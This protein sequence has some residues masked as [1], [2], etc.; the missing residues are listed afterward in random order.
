M[1]QGHLRSLNPNPY[2][3][4]TEGRKTAG[5]IVLKDDNHCKVGV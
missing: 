2:T 1:E 3:D 4:A 5:G